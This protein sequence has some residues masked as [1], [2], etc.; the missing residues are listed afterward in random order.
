MVRLLILDQAILGSSPSSSALI[1][2]HQKRHISSGMCLFFWPVPVQH[3]LL[4]VFPATIPPRK[5]IRQAFHS[6]VPF[7]H[8]EHH[9]IR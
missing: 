5:S 4:F 7:R 2:S 6:D 1:D 9:E 3:L 8:G